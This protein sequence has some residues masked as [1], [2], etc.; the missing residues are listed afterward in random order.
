MHCVF[1]ATELDPEE[2]FCRCRYTTSPSR[3]QFDYRR[4][5]TGGANRK[6]SSINRG[7]CVAG[8][9]FDGAAHHTG[10]TLYLSGVACSS[11]IEYPTGMNRKLKIF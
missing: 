3:Y 1:Q 8:E 11:S 9:V 10:T 2:D 7:L 4:P 6:P 5:R